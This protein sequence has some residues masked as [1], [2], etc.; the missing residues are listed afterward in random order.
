M[1]MSIDSPADQ[2]QA[3]LPPLAVDLPTIAKLT[4]LCERTISEQVQ[5]GKFPHVYV[6]RRVLFPV[7]AVH[8]WLTEQAL[9]SVKGDSDTNS[10]RVV[11]GLD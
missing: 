3:H 11:T 5:A 6:G 8:Q 9:A 2:H 4:S 7:S 1:T 10:A